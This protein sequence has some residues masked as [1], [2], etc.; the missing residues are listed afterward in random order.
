LSKKK[1]KYKNNKATYQKSSIATFFT[2]LSLKKFFFS[3]FGQKND[4]CEDILQKHMKK[5]VKKPKKWIFFK[6]KLKYTN[7]KASYQKSV[8]LRF[9]QF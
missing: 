7:N 9:L 2:I 5:G 1:L 6:K 8:S 4:A 3:H